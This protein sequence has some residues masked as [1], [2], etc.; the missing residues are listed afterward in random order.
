M[1]NNSRKFLFVVG[2]ALLLPLMSCQKNAENQRPLTALEARGKGVYF[3][4]CIQCHNPDPNLDGSIGPAV[5]GSSLDLITHRVLTRDYPT[6]YK[7][8][9]TSEVMP[10]FPQLKDDVPGLHA[11]LNSFVKN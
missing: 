9:R 6:G 8:K 7:P 5:A 4:N 2:G 10:D 3:S 1:L 11:Y